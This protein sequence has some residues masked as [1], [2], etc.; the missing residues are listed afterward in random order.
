VDLYRGA[1]GQGTTGLS[2]FIRQHRVSF[3]CPFCLA[4]SATTANGCTWLAGGDHPTVA[5]VCVYPYVAFAEQSG[6]VSL[7]FELYP[8]LQKWLAAFRSIPDYVEF[9][10]L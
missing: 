3:F 5:D 10:G 8:A 7:S 1:D 2:L 9:P 4:V 6:M